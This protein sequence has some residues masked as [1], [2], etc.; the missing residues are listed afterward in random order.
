MNIQYERRPYTSN[1]DLNFRVT[2]DDN[3]NSSTYTN[4][5]PNSKRNLISN[6][7]G[8]TILE[9]KFFRRIPVFFHKII[10]TYNL[11]RISVSKY[12]LGVEYCGLTEN[13]S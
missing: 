12:C 11:T 2:F 3:I 9:L 5:Y 4:F 8:K 6:Y 7:P 1:Y 13:L 10:Q